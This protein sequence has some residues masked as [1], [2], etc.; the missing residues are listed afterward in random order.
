[1]NVEE[2]CLGPSDLRELT[3]LL[4]GAVMNDSAHRKQW[5]LE[6]IAFLLEIDLPE[7]EDGIPA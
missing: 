2:S 5:Y 4:G 6:K 3:E 7:H 1:V